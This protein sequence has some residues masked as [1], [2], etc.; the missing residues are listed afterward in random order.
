MVTRPAGRDPADRARRE[1]V[2]PCASG[3]LLSSVNGGVTVVGLPEFMHLGFHLRKANTMSLHRRIVRVHRDRRS[4]G[5]AKRP[6]RAI[7]FLDALQPLEDRRLLSVYDVTSLA[8]DGSAGTLPSIIEQVNSDSTPDTIDF[9]LPGSAP[10][11][12]Q[13]TSELPQ[14]TNSVTIDGTS[15]AG[16]SGTPIVELNGSQAGGGSDGLQLDADN[17]TVQGLVINQFSNNG[18]EIEGGNGDLIQGNYIGTDATGMVGMGNGDDGITMTR[19][20]TTPSAA[21]R[22]NPQHHLGQRRQ[23]RPLHLRHELGDRRRGQLHRHRRHRHPAAGQRRQRHRHVRQRVGQHDR[24]HGR[25]RGQRDRGQQWPGH[26][27]LR[28]R[29]ARQPHPGE[30]HRHQCLGHRGAG[31]MLSGA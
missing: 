4:R 9:N 12:I 21:R 13:P 7:R 11:V 24:R 30:L 31:E 6:C 27:G 18:I 2:A 23:G 8:D 20:P 5:A 3:P 17:I 15:Q 1:P 28:R 25:R 22:P 19:P 14:I 29:I 26:R 16:Y 10:Y